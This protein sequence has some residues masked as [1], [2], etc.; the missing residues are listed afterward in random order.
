MPIDTGWSRT[1][2][3]ERVDL[4]QLNTR[5][6]AFALDPIAETLALVSAEGVARL[7]ADDPELAERLDHA[8]HRAAALAIEAFAVPDND[9]VEM[10]LHLIDLCTVDAVSRLVAQV[11]SERQHWLLAEYLLDRFP[12]ILD[13]PDVA[14]VIESASWRASMLFDVLRSI[15]DGGTRPESLDEPRLSQETY[16]PGGLSVNLYETVIVHGTWAKSAT[17]WREMTG[18]HNFWAYVK[19]VCPSLY[20]AGQEFSWSGGLSNNAREQGARD[21]INWWQTVGAP[22]QLQVIAHSHGCNVVYLACAMERT[23]N[24]ANM[25]ALGGPV[26]TWYPPT[27]AVASRIQRIHNVYSRYD[28]TQSVGSLGGRRGE[29]RTLGD[30]VSVTNHHVPW[31]NPATKLTQVWHSTLHEESVWRGNALAKLTLL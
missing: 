25:V 3:L 10:A 6:A 11:E 5:I 29:G 30:S 13:S 28:T 21:F 31:E 2:T 17:W 20:G 15:A 18:A 16:E 24:V 4:D 1:T 8:Q 26:R 22:A 14:A 19:G 9:C 12:N 7:A 23:L 27:I